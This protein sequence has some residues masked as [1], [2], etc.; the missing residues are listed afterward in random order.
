MNENSDK[1]DQIIDNFMDLDPESQ[2]RIIQKIRAEDED[3]A[4]V[5]QGLKGMQQK[6]KD[7]EKG[8]EKIKQALS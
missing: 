8:A 2:D 4:K 1:L 5:L 7:I 3:A 6:R